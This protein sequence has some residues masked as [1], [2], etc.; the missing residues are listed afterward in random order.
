MDISLAKIGDR[1]ISTRL[2]ESYYYEIIAFHKGD[3]VVAQ[4]MVGASSVVAYL[5]FPP[6][7]YHY[8]EFEKI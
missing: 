7:D 2:G 4:T 6:A 5:K 3:I 1:Y 8:H